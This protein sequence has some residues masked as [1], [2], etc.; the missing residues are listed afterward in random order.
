MFGP[1]TC[2]LLLQESQTYWGMLVGNSDEGQAVSR[3]YFS[4]GSL[5]VP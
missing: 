2:V 4:P 5:L 3:V 1:P